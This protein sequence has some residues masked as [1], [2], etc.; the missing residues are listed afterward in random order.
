VN[1]LAQSASGYALFIAALHALG[2][3]L[4]LPVVVA[5]PA[6]LGIGFLAYTLGL[7]HA[8]DADHIAAIDGVVRKLVQERRDPLGVGFFFSLGHS[9]VVFVLAVAMVALT[10]A[11]TSLPALREFGGFA[12]MLISGGFLVLIGVI[13]LIIWF[14]ILVL[15]RKMQREPDAGRGA[16]D[17]VLSASGIVA[18]FAKPL[19]ALV[20]SSRQAYPIGFLFGLGFDTA[21]EIA[22]LG[23]AAAA[24]ATALPLVNVL[25]LPLLFAAGMTLMDTLDGVFMTRAYHWAFST[26]LRKLYY[27]LTVTGLSVVAA[28]AIGGLELASVLGRTLG[29]TSG[30]WAGVQ[31][32]DFG[33]VGFGLVM[34]FALTWLLAA[35]VWRFGHFEQRPSS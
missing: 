10:R 14:D 16:L 33:S 35:G 4:L 23:I 29:T 32:I 18:R 2:V 22:L 30:F 27:N 3:A 25:A 11:A 26:P 31:Q 15:F 24:A 6:V 5:H 13:N 20:K 28:L 8:F 19:F 9:T 1:R 17:G 7:R 12:G 21:S 34:L